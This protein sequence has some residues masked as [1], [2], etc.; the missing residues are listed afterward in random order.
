[1][2]IRRRRITAAA[3]HFFAIFH[4]QIALQVWK[5]ILSILR[6]R[7]WT[8]CATLAVGRLQVLSGA[9]SARPG[10]AVL[11]SYPPSEE[12][13]AVPLTIGAQ[14]KIAK[15][16]CSLSPSEFFSG[17]LT[18]GGVIIKTPDDAAFVYM[19]LVRVCAQRIV[20][21]LPHTS[22]Q[23]L[24]TGP[25]II[26]KFLHCNGLNSFLLTIDHNRIVFFVCVVAEGCCNHCQAQ[27]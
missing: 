3:K 24:A 8:F 17:L 12:P 27:T 15:R 23:F 11:P 14:L 25:R 19:L 10:P 2:Q 21:D 22:K 5:S 4:R 18:P 6:S 20:Y 7:R 13:K 1:M 9:S 16:H 26:T